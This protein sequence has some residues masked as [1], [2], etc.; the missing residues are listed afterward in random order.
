MCVCGWW[1]VWKALRIALNLCRGNWTEIKEAE[2]IKMDI[3]E[4]LKKYFNYEEE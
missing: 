1:G 2:E 4:D 3:D